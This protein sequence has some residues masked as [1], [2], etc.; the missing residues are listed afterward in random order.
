MRFPANAFDVAFV[1]GIDPRL[2]W[3][4]NEAQGMDVWGIVAVAFGLAADALAVSIASGVDLQ[5]VNTRQ[6]FR[7]AFHFGLFQSLMPIVGW[8]AGSFVS[9]WFGAF[10]HWLAFGLL[11]GIGMKM[12]LD[13]LRQEEKRSRRDPSRGWT[14]VALALATSMDALAVGLGLAF[15]RVSIWLPSLVIGFVTASLSALGMLFGA[16]LGQKVGLWATW[17]GGLML[18]GIGLKI[19]LEHLGS[20]I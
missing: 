12:I 13:S 17:L 7:V 3:L 9:S 10:E 16:R 5:E 20:Q 4:L 18:I 19:L 6:V 8:L 1:L 15:V 2:G 11:V 14:L